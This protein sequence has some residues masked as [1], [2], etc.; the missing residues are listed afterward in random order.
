MSQS[1]ASGD[2]KLL[3]MERFGLDEPAAYALLRRIAMNERLTIV[4]VARRLIDVHRG[5]RAH[6]TGAGRGG[7]SGS[8]P[9]SGMA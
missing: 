2:A 4:E 6:T 5:A 9:D 1:D 3:L 8:D 7:K